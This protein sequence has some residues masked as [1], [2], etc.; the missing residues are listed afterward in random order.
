MNGI[1][2]QM[3]TWV[4]LI[5]VVK[6]QGLRSEVFWPDVELVRFIRRL[7]LDLY[8][9]GDGKKIKISSIRGRVGI[10]DNI[11]ERPFR[12]LN[13][14]ETDTGGSED[15]SKTFAIRTLKELGKIAP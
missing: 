14:T 10:F 8:R 11:P 15:F 6:H 3:L 5:D 12:F 4:A 7:S 13:R 1:Q 2:L 9:S